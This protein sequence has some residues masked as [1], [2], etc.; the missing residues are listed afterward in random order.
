MN[1]PT[2][3][4]DKATNIK[5][6]FSRLPFFAWCFLSSIFVYAAYIISTIVFAIFGGSVFFFNEINQSQALPAIYIIAVVVYSLISIVYLYYT[7]VF[8]VRRLHDVDRSG[9]WLLLMLVPLVNLVFFVYLAL[10]RGTV[11]ANR[12]GAP[13]PT[14]E[15]EKI[16]GIIY[17]ILIPV[18]IIGSSL[19]LSTM[20]A[21][22]P[23]LEQSQ[24]NLDEQMQQEM[25]D[26][27]S[28]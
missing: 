2:L 16:M 21:Y 6:R 25:E 19:A 10:R 28:K 1:T 20:Y 13:R 26:L 7:I 24:L 23:Q 12:F 14:K 4:F 15:W 9:W 3:Q 11:E 8:S 18:S 22:L 17:I 27:S 5:G